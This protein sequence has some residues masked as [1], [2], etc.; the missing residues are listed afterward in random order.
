MDRI[1]CF[2]LR[3]SSFR[4][5]TANFSLMSPRPEKQP[6]EKSFYNLAGGQTKS[7]AIE[8]AS[9]SLPKVRGALKGIDEKFFRNVIIGISSLSIPFSASPARGVTPASSLS[10]NSASVN[11]TF[12]LGWNLSPAYLKRETDKQ[13]PH[14]LDTGSDVYLY[15]KADDLVPEFEKEADVSFKRDSN[16]DYIINEKDFPDNLFKVRFYK[17]R[18]E[19]LFAQ[20]ECR[21]DIERIRQSEDYYWNNLDGRYVS[22]LNHKLRTVRYARISFTG[23]SF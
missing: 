22:K 6:D 15:S 16:E 9:I 18:I 1:F 2:D 5:F 23:M 14:C 4:I 12:R 17:P 3:L 11:G 8:V 10:Y 21:K 20:I 7:N 19:G 13:L